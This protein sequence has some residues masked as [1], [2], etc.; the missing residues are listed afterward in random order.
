MT[1]GLLLEVEAE[2]ELFARVNR[3]LPK[4]P[5]IPQ[6]IDQPIFGLCFKPF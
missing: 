1:L 6:Q 5:I 4:L 3:Y 2:W